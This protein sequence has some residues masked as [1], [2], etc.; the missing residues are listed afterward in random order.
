MHQKTPFGNPDGSRSDIQEVIDS[1]VSFGHHHL[2][3]PADDGSVRVIVGAKGSGKT[4]YLRRVRAAAASNPSVY[5]DAVQQDL[6]VTSNVV[7][8][9]QC[10]R[11]RDLTEKWMQLWYCAIVRS[12]ASHL[13]H[14]RPLAPYLS[15]EQRAELGEYPPEFVPRSRREVSVYSQATDI[16]NSHHTDRGYSKYFDDPLWAE[17]ATTIGDILSSMPPIYFFIDSVDEEYA[18]APMF[19]LQCQKGL[20]FRTMRFL[21]DQHFGGRL[22]VI[23]CVR[24]HVLASVLRGEHQNRYRGE[25][26]IISLEWDYE[27]AEYFLREKISRLDERAL[28]RKPQAG[29]TIADWLGLDTIENKG[30]GITEPITQYLLRHTRLLPRDVV[31][32]GNRLCQEVQ[33]SKHKGQALDPVTIRRV[34]REVA[35]S[36]ANEQ[37]AICANHIASSGMPSDAV[38]MELEE[39]YTGDSEYSRG[40]REKLVEVIRGI[41]V[42]RF[43]RAELRRALEHARELFGAGSDPLSV[44]WQNRLL[45]FT[46]E[47]P[48]GPVESFFSETRC[49]HFTLPHDQDEYCLHSSL[50]DLVGV[51]PVGPPVG[52]ATPGRGALPTMSDP[53]QHD[54]PVPE[55]IGRYRVLGRLGKGGFGEVFLA[56]DKDLVRRIAIKA[57]PAELARDPVWL[58]RFR[59]EAQVLAN[60]NHPNIATIHSIEE[61]GQRRFLTMEYI[62]GRTLAELIDAGPMPLSEVLV[63]ARQLA[64]ALGA[65]HKGGVVH[66]DLKPS[67]I[68]LRNDRLLKVLDFGLAKLLPR[69]GVVRD[70]GGTDRPATGEGTLLGTPGY[71]APEQVRGHPVDARADI[72]AF[73]CVLFECLAQR[74]AI[75]GATVVDRLS[76]T[77]QQEPPWRSLPPKTPRWLKK[78]LERCLQKDPASRP[79]SIADVEAA[80][81]DG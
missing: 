31:I 7:K 57:L 24:D 29:P 21:R 51:A 26:H 65:A 70:D 30:R 42:D 18:N 39:I 62:D 52:R 74:P 76:A 63:V 35:T 5:T 1:F 45:G 60:L 22:H 46:V 13:L 58:R 32:L 78:L 77:L 66:R 41:G 73:G 23:A 16:I 43:G 4:V 72:W 79:A 34:V 64:A 54:L 10:F 81:A 67:N 55:R 71:M 59:K 25:P 75:D 33:L 17:L 28:M 6:P 14:A 19:W 68:M 80:V 9:C 8:F 38:R 48:D 56:Q 50:I 69:E 15:P 61:H 12:L 3:I 40:L 53:L 47:S 2:G 20:F 36:F 49:D 44:L 27:A 37:L 11:R